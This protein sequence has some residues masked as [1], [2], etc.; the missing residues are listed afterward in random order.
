LRRKLGSD[1]R[2]IG[3][4]NLAKRLNLPY[5]KILK[6]FSYGFLFKAGDEKGHPL[7]SDIEFL[8]QWNQDRDSVLFNICGLKDKSDRRQ[9]LQILNGLT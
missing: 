5:D 9:V 8:K 2:F 3:I 6:A 7:P 4:V 1:D